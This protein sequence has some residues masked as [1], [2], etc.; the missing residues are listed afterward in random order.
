MVKAGS[1]YEAEAGRFFRSLG[2]TAVVQAEIEGARGKHDI[3][4]WVTGSVGAFEVRWVVECKDWGSNVPK[5]KV[6]TLQAI[7]Q[8]VGADRGWLLSEKGFQAG[9]IRCAEHT[10]ITLT[11][12]AELR[13]HTKDYIRESTLQRLF[14]EIDALDRRL[15]GAVSDKR[16]QADPQKGF[17]YPPLACTLM[18]GRLPMLQMAVRRAMVDDFPICVDVIVEDGKERGLVARSYDELI[19]LV[20]SL[21]AA[22]RKELADALD[23][24]DREVI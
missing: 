2:L 17:W 8:D 23:E 3:D 5:D 19:G 13:E 20:N 18:M 7:V 16:R 11:S 21:L 22:R 10:N 14:F 4:V 12:L 1:E 15:H 24:L 6:L 9:A